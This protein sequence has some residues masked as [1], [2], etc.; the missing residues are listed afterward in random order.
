MRP[1]EEC[2]I[3]EKMRRGVG[4]IRQKEEGEGK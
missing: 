4:L 1:K 3:I 2:K